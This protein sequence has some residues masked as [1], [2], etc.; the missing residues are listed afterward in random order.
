[1]KR[2]I[3]VG[4]LL[5]CRPL[6]AEAQVPYILGTWTLD[7]AASQLPG[8]APRVHVRRYSLAT[9][10]TLIGLAVLVDAGGNPDFLQFAAKSDGKDYAEFNSRL[11]AALQIDGAKSPRDYTETVIDERTVAWADKY[12][13]KVIASGRKWVSEDGK[14]LTFTS[15]SRNA[16]GDE[17]TYRFVF[18]RQ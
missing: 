15:V 6:S 3:L 4:L 13:G 10:G 8:P 9:D 7:A 5:A 14:T 17:V 18:D 11:L 2:A 1:M 16:R 12:D